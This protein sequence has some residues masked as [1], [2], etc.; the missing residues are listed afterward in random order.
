[1]K[2]DVAQGRRCS[3]MLVD[4]IT[5]IDTGDAG[6]AVISASHGGLSSGGF[7]LEVPLALVF[8]ND[9]GVGK[10][11]AGIA[12]LALLQANN[13]PAGCVS[14][15][16]ARI[17][18]VEDMWDNGVISHLNPRALRAGL[19]VGEKLSAAVQRFAQAGVGGGLG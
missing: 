19:A 15:L 1:M 2:L 13:V 10:D 16:S 9:A 8:F 5:R 17:G 14:H 6:K 4:S 7:A 11:E 12:A 3:V 18:D